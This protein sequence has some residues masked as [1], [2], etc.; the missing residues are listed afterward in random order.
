VSIL[1]AAVTR[2][3]RLV[4]ARRDAVPDSVRLFSQRIRQRRWRAA[5]PWLIG[6]GVLAV[7]AGAFGAV[8]ST[9]LLGVAQV[10][11]VGTRLISP[12]EVRAAA[13]VAP[14]TPL[15]RVDAKTVGRRV[16]TLAPV[17]RAT[18]TRSWPRTL[19]V[20]VVERTPAATVPLRG[21]YAVVDRTGVVF[22][23]VA[24]RP[25]ALPVLKVNAP[26]GNDPA[27]RAGLTVLGNLPPAL[28]DQLVD[29]VADA[30][31]RI[32]LDLRDGRQIVWGD[33]TE[34]DA[35]VRVALALLPGDQPVIDVSAPTVIPTR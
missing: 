22:D 10:R 20:R 21:R 5:R 24:S 25:S 35:K 15:I 33:A 4:R 23:W 29:V 6:L 13:R 34:N 16:A 14:G 31:A 1:G 12:G 27:T 30:P 11:V 9:P 18:V 28:R 26:G 8:Y 17:A 7:L 32:R 19:V 2:P 3:W